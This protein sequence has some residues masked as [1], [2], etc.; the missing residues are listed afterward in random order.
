MSG[1]KPIDFKTASQ[2]FLKHTDNLCFVLSNTH[3]IQEVS[4]SL[5]KMLG[6]K[7][8]DIQ[9]CPITDVFEKYS[10]QSFINTKLPI[11]KLS[12]TGFISSNHKELQIK[13]DIIPIYNKNDEVEQIYIIGKQL[14]DSSNSQV[15]HLQLENIV[16]YAPGFFYWKDKNSIYLG[17]NDEFAQLAGLQYRSEVVGKSDFDLIW[18]ERAQLYVD[19]DQTVMR[20]GKPILNHEE[21]IT[22]SNNRTITAITNKVPLRD[23]KNNVIGMM[24]ITTD[25]TKQKEIEEALV[26]ANI[27]AE[28]ATLLKTNFIQNMQHDI[29][30][31]ASSVWAVLDNLVQNRQ[32]PDEELLTM[33]RNS[34]KQLLSICNDVIDFDRIENSIVPVLSKRFN[35]RQLIN[36]VIELN[37][38]TAF[39]KGLTLSSTIDRDIPEVIKGDERRLSRILINLLG[40]A[41][42]FTHKG[43]ILLSVRLI[44]AYEKNYILQFILQDTGIGIPLE[45]QNTIYEKFNRLNPANRNTYNGSGLGLRIV[46]KYVE[47]M[48][49]EINVQSE[50]DKGS[51]FYIDIPFEKALVAKTYDSMTV[52]E[53]HR[54]VNKKLAPILDEEEPSESLSTVT[55]LDIN[56]LDVL[57]IED[58][59]LARKIGL[60]LLKSLGLNVSTAIDVASAIKSLN[61]AKYDFVVADIG[62]PDGTGID[63]INTV[64]QNKNAINFLTPFIALTANADTSTIEACKEACFLHVLEKPLKTPLL[65]SL[66]EQ[67][68]LVPYQG[69][70]CDINDDSNKPLGAD[71]PASEKELFEIT[72]YPLFDLTNAITTLGDEGIL[73]ELLKDLKFNIPHEKAE[74]ERAHINNDWKRIEELAHKAKSGASYCGTLRLKYACQYL[75]RYR[76]AGYTNLLEN[77]Y[78]QLLKVYD[79]TKLT[80]EEWL[81]K[82]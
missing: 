74:I 14:A 8:K 82:E 17:C 33:L 67:F 7:K 26:L 30:T 65:Q 56:K 19:I 21:K 81:A 25:I 41:L 3:T 51:I 27:A 46:K 63:V 15:E 2:L 79:D 37:Q 53:T 38:I 68:V 47:D 18:R 71:L 29:R 10:V 48:N 64:K 59:M 45:K 76:K 57:L 22:I 52:T 54:A 58:D 6:C 75:E 69:S 28:E 13:W 50:P 36:N 35:L 16:R 72:Q 55:K 80:I 23:S 62:L 61:R 42:K 5:L 49:G 44:E 78:Q 24:G 9:N 60:I 66:I 77:L 70:P 31:P 11:R 43:F 12:T 34:S 20:T 39:D 40:N 73:R 1:T 4:A 32:T